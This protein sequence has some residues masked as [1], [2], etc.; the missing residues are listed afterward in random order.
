MLQV[1]I[2]LQPDWLLLKVLALQVPLLLHEVCDIAPPMLQVPLLLHVLCEVCP[3][4]LHTPLVVHVLC[5]VKLLL[6][7][8]PPRDKQLLRLLL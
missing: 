7:H 6:L 2:L 5:R 1:P 4:T 3:P 8:E